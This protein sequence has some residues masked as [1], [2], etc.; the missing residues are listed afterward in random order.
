MISDDS[1]KA[2]LE[3]YE[4][5]GWT[6]Q[7]VLLTPEL[8]AALGSQ[9]NELF[10]G[11]NLRDAKIDAAWFTR[12]SKH[13]GVAWELRELNESPFALIEVMDRDATKDELEAMRSVVEQKLGERQRAAI[14]PNNNS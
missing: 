6:L 4:R 9:I 7:Q 8:R 3:Q 12:E 2:L 5:F 14:T 11:V 13:G 1:V 10:R